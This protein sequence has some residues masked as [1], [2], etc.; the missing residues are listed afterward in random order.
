MRHLLIIAFI[1]LTTLF[2]AAQSKPIPLAT[3]ED[4]AS[5]QI[6]KSMPLAQRT[7]GYVIYLTDKQASDLWVFITKAKMDGLDFNGSKAIVELI[8]AL[9]NQF[10]NQDKQRDA[11]QKPK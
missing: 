10:D 7:T 11:A 5:K 4:T 6:N 2:A 9:G 3:K 8:S 1:T